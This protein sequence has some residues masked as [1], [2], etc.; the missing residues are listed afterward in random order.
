MKS[1]KINEPFELVILDIIG[2]I[3]PASKNDNKYIFVMVDHSTKMVD[4]TAGKTQTVKGVSRIVGHSQIKNHLFYPQSDSNTER[5][6]RKM[7]GML[8]CFIEENLEEWDEYL[9]LLAFAYNTAIHATTGMQPFQML[10][11]R[12]PRLPIDL[13]FPTEVIFHVELEPE[14]YVRENKFAIKKVFEF[15]AT[16]SEGNLQRQNFFYD[17]YINFSY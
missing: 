1:I 8:R 3:S 15:V 14:D 11:G 7:E 6:N 12:K 17:R 9:S 16:I 13:I 5:F 4:L 10:Y 2:P